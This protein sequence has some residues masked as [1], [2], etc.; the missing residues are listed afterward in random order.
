MVI[1]QKINKWT[2]EDQ[3]RSVVLYF[4]KSL[5]KDKSIT[6]FCQDDWGS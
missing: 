5:R 6:Y 1:G 4:G 3:E 2:F